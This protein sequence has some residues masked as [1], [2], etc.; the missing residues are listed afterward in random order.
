MSNDVE[1][2]WSKMKLSLPC[3]HCHKEG[4]L[5]IVTELDITN[6]GVYEVTCANGHSS[7]DHI[8]NEKY[9]LLFDL[10]LLA[11]DN[12]FSREAVSSFAVSLERF[13]EYCIRI[14]LISKN[15]SGDSINN[16]WKLVSSQSERQVGAFYFQ[17]LSVFNV[18]PERFP[19]KQTDFRNSVIHKGYIPSKDEVLRYAKEVYQYIIKHT[20]LLKKELQT[21][22]DN[23]FFRRLSEVNHQY[24][25][26]DKLVGW[27]SIG[28]TLNSD[29]SIEQL[30][31]NEFNFEMAVY[32]FTDVF[33]IYTK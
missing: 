20:I 9:E 10:G 27:F 3:G 1:R 31:R 18:V 25:D 30:E 14:M 23:H 19:Q 13:Y 21:S 26:N 28:T 29:I 8:K 7:I 2:E 11:V 5:D 24:R 22:M 6:N 17:Y 4:Q 16:A 15:V 12:G 32:Y 33:P